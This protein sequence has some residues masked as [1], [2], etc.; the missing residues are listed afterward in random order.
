MADEGRGVK[1]AEQATYLYCVVRSPRTPSLA[2]ALRGLPGCGRPRV[3]DAGRSVWL[4]AA[5]A[6]LAH[7]GAAPIER[8]LRDLDWV[9]ACAVAHEA[10]VE[11]AA[12]AGTVIPMKLF[13]LFASDARALAHITSIRARLDTL[14]R[15]LAGRQEWGVRVAVDE[16]RARRLA[17]ATA[18][19]ATSGLTAG[20]RFL[21]LKMRQ[22]EAA[23]QLRSRGREEVE[24]VF[25]ALAKHADDTRRRPPAEA[26][27]ARRLLLDAAFLVPAKAASRFR[28]TARSAGP[29]LGRLGYELTLS[30]PW[31]AYNFVGEPR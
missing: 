28:S 25:A 27:G 3:L 9:S 5:A 1:T 31:P 14:F 12:R 8:R 16:A 20:K 26:E 11:H 15:R 2:R 13:T 19:K 6:P 7:Y 10:V 22:Q 30:G 18:R 24:A 23:R 21:A 4:V 29:R 17:D